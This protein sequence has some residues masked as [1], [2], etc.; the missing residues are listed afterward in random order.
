MGMKT[1]LDYLDLIV[2]RLTKPTRQIFGCEACIFATGLHTCEE[3]KN[4]LL[5]MTKDILRRDEI[6]FLRTIGRNKEANDIRY[7]ISEVPN[8]TNRD[9]FDIIEGTKLVRKQDASNAK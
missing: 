7:R 9:G 2:N 6:E 3:K 5:L 1:K 4:N 8:I